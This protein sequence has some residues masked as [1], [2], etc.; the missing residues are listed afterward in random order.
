M[1]KC[2][3]S[4]LFDQRQADTAINGQTLRE[5]MVHN[6]TVSPRGML[7]PYVDGFCKRASPIVFFY[8]L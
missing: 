1:R 6:L 3:P 8:C 5:W 2:H 4:D 7:S